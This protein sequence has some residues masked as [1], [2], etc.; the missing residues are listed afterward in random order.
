MGKSDVQKTS[1]E[2]NTLVVRGRRL[3]KSKIAALKYEEVEGSK[4]WHIRACSQDACA[5][6]A[7]RAAC[8]RPLAHCEVFTKLREAIVVA[9][10]ANEAEGHPPTYPHAHPPTH[11]PTPVTNPHHPHTHTLPPHPQNNTIT[12]VRRAP[13]TCGRTLLVPHRLQRKRAHR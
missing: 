2:S 13:R 9:R 10:E 5:L 6:L 8:Y 3:G 7:G 4:F 1:F 11:I 12:K